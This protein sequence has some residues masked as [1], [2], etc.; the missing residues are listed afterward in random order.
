MATEPTLHSTERTPGVV[1]SGLLM[2][3][4]ALLLELLAFFSALSGRLDVWTS[5]AAL[6]VHGVGCAMAAHGMHGMMPASQQTSRQTG[7]LFLFAMMFFMPLLGL[8]G[9]LGGLLA[10]LYFPNP[11][12]P[13]PPWITIPIPDLPHQPSTVGAHPD[14]GDGALSAMLRY[15]PN[16]ERRLSAVLAVRH[17]RDEHDA[18]V[19]RLA[20]TDTVDDVRLLAYSILDRKE[21]SFNLRLKSL[22][23]QLPS[24]AADDEQRAKLEKRLAQTHL[25]MIELGL[26]R[27]EVLLFMLIEARKHV[28]AALA[29]TPDDRESLFLLGSIALRQDELVTAEG[30]FLKAQV[31]GMSIEKVLPNLAELAFRQQRFS[32]VTHYLRAIDPIC[33]RAQPRLSGIAT[34]WLKEE[35]ACPPKPSST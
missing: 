2:C 24:A 26:C 4:G 22:L 13:P 6:I 33:F 30:A 25:E 7:L 10:E 23:G 11:P 15:C 18:E 20:L 28:D 16:P 31:M 14:Y 32:M 12:P 35:G 27:G 17:L 19:L 29:L 1:R 21:Q 34:H 9:L 5:I 3:C 8:L